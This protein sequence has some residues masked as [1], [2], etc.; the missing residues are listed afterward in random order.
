M[1]SPAFDLA[2]FLEAQGVG[3]FATDIHVAVEPD[4]PDDTVTLYDMPG[5]DPDTDELD[6]YRHAVQV[7]VRA[8]DYPSAYARQ[9][10]IRQLLTASTPLVANGS[11]FGGISPVGDIF[12]LGRDESN[13]HLL[14]ADYR[15]LR[16]SP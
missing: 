9:A 13:R 5:A 15:C 10:Q 14:T 2:K 12:S 11:R 1:N 3:T 7:R 4:T 6:V 8:V 16:S